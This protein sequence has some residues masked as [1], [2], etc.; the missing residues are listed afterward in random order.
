MVYWRERLHL[1]IFTE[2]AGVCNLELESS[3]AIKPKDFAGN[4]SRVG[5][6]TFL[7]ADRAPEASE[8]DLEPAILIARPRVTFHKPQ[9][10][11]SCY[12]EITLKQ[13]QGLRTQ[14]PIR[15][16]MNNRSGISAAA[17]KW[18]LERTW[19]RAVEAD[20]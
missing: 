6:E 12:N 5:C 10:A 19:V 18:T 11:V 15:M 1:A 20:D 7:V 8:E 4:S 17:I 14:T 2:S 16:V 3:P 13:P 9:I